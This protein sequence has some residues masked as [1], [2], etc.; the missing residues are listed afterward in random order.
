MDRQEIARLY[1]MHA[2]T[3]TQAAWHYTGSLHSAQDC[4][5]EAFLRLMKQPD[6][7]QTHILPWLIRTA[8]NIAKD[9]LRSAEYKRT[10]PLDELY[11]LPLFLHLARGY[12]IR[13]TAKII[14]KGFNTT[15]SLIRRG[16]K[17]LKE[18]YEKEG[19]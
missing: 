5:Q 8:V 1:S 3:V 2:D 9:I 16:K 15:A 4:A 13:E 12:T 18:A 6:M 11:R 17:L 14:D 19:F 10:I 7:E